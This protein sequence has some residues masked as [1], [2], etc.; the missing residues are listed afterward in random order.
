MIIILGLITLKAAGQKPNI[1][2]LPN[3]SN[4]IHPEAMLDTCILY[5]TLLVIDA[6]PPVPDSIR[7]DVTG[8]MMAR[9]PHPAVRK[10]SIKTEARIK[11]GL[12]PLFFK[13]INPLSFI[14]YLTALKI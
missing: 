4:S 13:K 14:I 8:S 10:E 2:L 1:D 6:F 5:D 11:L 7:E 12:Y 3:A 9:E